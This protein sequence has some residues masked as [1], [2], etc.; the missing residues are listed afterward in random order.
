MSRSGWGGGGTPRYSPPPDSTA[1]GVVDT[2]R[3]V[4]LLRSRR[5]TFLLPPAYVVRREGNS[6]TLFVCPHRGGGGVRAPPPGGYPGQVPPG[7]VPGSGTPPGGY[8][9]Q[10]P[11]RGGTRVRYPPGGY[12][13]QVPPPGGYPGQVPPRGGTRVRYPP[14]GV[15][16]SG[17]PPG[18]YPGQVPPRGG[19]RVRYPPGGVPGSGTPRGVPGSG[20]PPGGYPGQ[21]PPGGGTRVRYPPRGGTRVRYPPRGGTRVRYPPPGGGTRVG[22]QKEYSLHGGRYASCVHAGGLSCLVYKSSPSHHQAMNILTL[23]WLYATHFFL[24]DNF[25]L[26]AQ[27]DKFKFSKSIRNNRINY[28]VLLYMWQIWAKLIFLIRAY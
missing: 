16:G 7:G 6:F 4:C 8:P 13:G 21:V 17:T 15:P 3:S 11:P 5:R 2:L 19:T 23:I 25:D 1:Y 10:V 9:G 24:V 18:G 28:D 27:T 26:L 20:T 22:Q 14:R 12:P